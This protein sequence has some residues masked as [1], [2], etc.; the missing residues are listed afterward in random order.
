MMATRRRVLT[1]LETFE[2]MMGAVSESARVYPTEKLRSKLGA[3]EAGELRSGSL[4]LGTGPGR[5]LIGSL[6]VYRLGPARA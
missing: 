3:T 1:Q 5:G 6:S 2:I 4:R